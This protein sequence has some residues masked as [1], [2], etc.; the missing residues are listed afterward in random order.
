M[1]A[2]VVLTDATVEAL[3]EVR[4]AD[5][6]ALSAISGIGPDKINR[7]AQVLLALVTG[8]PVPR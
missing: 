3:A 7:Y 2:Y 8:E 5:V 6:E 1:P 4:P